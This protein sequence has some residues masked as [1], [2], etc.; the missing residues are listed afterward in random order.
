VAY[1]FTHLFVCL[2][3]T[4]HRSCYIYRYF[5]LYY[6]LFY[7]CYR[8]KKFQR[9]YMELE[10]CEVVVLV[11]RLLN[12]V[13][14][15]V[16]KLASSR[17]SRLPQLLEAHLK[18]FFITD[19]ILY[20]TN[21]QIVLSRKYCAQ[22]ICY[23]FCVEDVDDRKMKKLTVAIRPLTPNRGVSVDNV[24]DIRSIAS[25]LRL[26]PTVSVS[27]VYDNRLRLLE[28]HCCIY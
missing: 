25:T 24:D 11:C 19:T 9:G 3:K 14:F 13:F 6:F 26:S 2:Y 21:C 4:H 28:L 10:I 12:S 1:F 27:F 22:T 17:E 15:L 16:K 18:L 5:L 20:Y 23:L 8:K 7:A